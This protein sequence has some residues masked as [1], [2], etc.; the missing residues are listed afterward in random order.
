MTDRDKLVNDPHRQA[1]LDVISQL[2]AE[3]EPIEN[4]VRY[5]VNPSVIWNTIYRLEAILSND[6]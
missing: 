4:N 5:T 1:L 2:K 3:L 6:I